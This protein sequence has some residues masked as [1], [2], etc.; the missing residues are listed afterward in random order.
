MY[1]YEVSF[2]KIVVCQLF[3]R[4]P[5]HVFKD[6]IADRPSPLSHPI[7]KQFHARAVGIAV[8]QACGL[9]AQHGRDT[10]LLAQLACERGFRDFA[11]LD[12]AAGEL[13][14]ERHGAMAAALA[15][16]V[17]PARIGD[18]GGDYASKARH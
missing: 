2:E 9:F 7:E 14:F 10:Q 5:A 18:Q 11:G 16:E 12:F 4:D 17:V 1:E 8:A 15:D 3:R 6:K 13:P